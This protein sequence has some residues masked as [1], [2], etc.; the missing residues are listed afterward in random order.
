MFRKRLLKSPLFAKK[1]KLYGGVKLPGFKSLSNSTSIKTLSIPP[2]LVIPLKQHIGE[3]AK[4][5]V[6][7][8]ERVL[9][10]QVIAETSGYIS[11][12]VHAS[13]SGIVA[14]I[15]ARPIP[16]TADIKEPCIVIHPDG[17]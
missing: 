4:P 9:K 16:H 10:G 1:K 7:A 17:K 11:A 6:A 5:I 12:P 2:V 15:E 14:A 3:P 8:G 13:S